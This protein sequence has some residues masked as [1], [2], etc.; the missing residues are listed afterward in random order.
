[1]RAIGCLFIT[2]VVLCAVTALNSQDSRSYPEDYYLAMQSLVTDVIECENPDILIDILEPEEID[3]V[4][5]FRMFGVPPVEFS[6][7]ALGKSV[8]GFR[9]DLIPVGHGWSTY[10]HTW[11]FELE[12]KNLKLVF[13]LKDSYLFVDDTQEKHGRYL[14]WHWVGDPQTARK[15][16]FEYKRGSYQ[17]IPG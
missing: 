3:G 12:N 9:A 10:R 14:L 7:E 16:Y 5:Y 11:I 17:E 1:M 15:A 8:E 13:E 4:A 2:S 6:R